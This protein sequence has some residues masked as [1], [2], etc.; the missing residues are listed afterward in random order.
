MSE[1]SERVFVYGTLR[2]GGSNA[3]RMD[4]AGFV[5]EARVR[6]RLYRI[7]W[8]P[9]L[10]LDPTAGWVDGE[11]WE[12]TAEQLRALDEFEGL[13]EGERE[14]VEYRRVAASVVPADREGVWNEWR[15]R[16]TAAWVWEWK[17]PTDERH[18]ISNGD[19]LQPGNQGFNGTFTLFGCLGFVA[20][21]IGSAVILAALR[22]W[23]I[24]ISRTHWIET[25]AVILL[26][27]MPPI[28]CLGFFGLAASRREGWRGLRALGAVAGALWL[29]LAL[30]IFLGRG[31]R[32]IQWSV[33]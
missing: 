6:G 8:Y 26:A 27:L 29:L 3:H 25:S 2:R 15:G 19:W 16:G 14:G 28:I 18:R 5:G 23:I 30:M 22:H 9:G 12:V 11:I 20:V 7:S 32:T 1:G 31:A 21:P 4:G 33:P 17:G 24:P 10:V 13:P